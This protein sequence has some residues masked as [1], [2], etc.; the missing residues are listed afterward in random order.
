MWSVQA[1]QTILNNEDYKKLI[2]AGAQLTDGTSQ[3]KD[4]AEKL[5]NGAGN[6]YD[7]TVELMNGAVELDDGAQK[8]MDGMQEFYDEGIAKLM[9]VFGDNLTDVLDRMQ[10][11]ADAGAEYTNFSGALSDEDQ[12]NT[13]RFIIKTAA[14]K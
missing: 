9:D 2:A 11:V 12:N 14:V 5:N 6:L 4:G 7:G 3:L 13:V 1:L 8:L 10:A